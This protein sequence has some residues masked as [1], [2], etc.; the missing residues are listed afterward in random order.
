MGAGTALIEALEGLMEAGAALMKAMK[1][2]FCDDFDDLARPLAVCLFKV[3]IV[4]VKNRETKAI[5]FVNFTFFP[6][7]IESVSY[8][9]K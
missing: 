2:D 1:V 5:L 8:Q 3:C 4:K 9:N 6:T 7:F